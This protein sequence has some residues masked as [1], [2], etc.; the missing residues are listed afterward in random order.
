M[1]DRKSIKFVGRPTVGKIWW[2][3]NTFKHQNGQ[4]SKQNTPSEQFYKHNLFTITK[5]IT[6]V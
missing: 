1:N 2:V 3:D 6:S 5:L 4:V